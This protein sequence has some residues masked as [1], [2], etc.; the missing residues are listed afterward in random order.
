MI[1]KYNEPLFRPPAEAESL[2]FQVAYGCPHNTCRFC[3]MYKTVRY[4]LRSKEEIVAEIRRA[5]EYYPDTTRIFLADGDVM[6]LPFD[7]LDE[8]LTVINESF[9]RLSRVNIYANG[10]SI[11]NK[12]KSQ[13]EILRHK[14]L[15]TLYTGLE[16]GSQNVLDRFSKTESVEDMISA[17]QLAQ[18]IGFRCSV[19]ILL[20]LGGTD[21][22]KEH[23]EQT[24]SALNRMKPALLSALRY[25]LIPGLPLP[26]GFQPVSERQAIQE[27]YHIIAGLQ[28]DRT[29]FRANHTSNPLPLAGRLPADKEKLLLQLEEEFHSNQVPDQYRDFPIEFL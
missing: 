26:H 14:K 8:Y 3:G 5:A 15:N 25:I 4:H 18:M 19:M 17:I 16:S 6:A 12:T 2:I 27:L 7:L 9:P 28:L 29:V 23:I 11:L 20:G 21:M 10:S 1:I 22:Q 24:V 13:L